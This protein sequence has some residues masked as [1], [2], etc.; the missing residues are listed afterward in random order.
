MVA[1]AIALFLTILC[2]LLAMIIEPEKNTGMAVF[3]AVFACVSAVLVLTSAKDLKGKLA[4]PKLE[5]GR[6]YIVELCAHH[7]LHLLYDDKDGHAR[8]TP[9]FKWDPS[10]CPP[11]KF[12]VGENGSF[13]ALNK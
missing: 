11:N 5:S 12:I 7:V 8:A 6:I 1:V 13:Q 2:T 10:E 4:E 9:Y 3:L